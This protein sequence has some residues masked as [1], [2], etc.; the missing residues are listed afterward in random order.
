[1]RFRL[2]R[3]ASIIERL[4]NRKPPPTSILVQGTVKNLVPTMSGCEA[5]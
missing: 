3:K 5:L 2:A 4:P 1:M